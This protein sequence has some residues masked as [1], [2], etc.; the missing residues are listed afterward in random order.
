MR[1]FK[2]LKTGI[3]TVFVLGVIWTIY[4]FT[5]SVYNNLDNNNLNYIPS[6]SDVIIQIDATQLIKESIEGLLV[7]EDNE[8]VQ[9]LKD[10]Q[11]EGTD[12]EG[13]Q[14]GIALN[15]DVLFSLLKKTIT[16]YMVR[17]ST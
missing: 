9:L 11:G 7:T 16:S 14:T 1:N 6:N 13:K 5:A 12:S 15:T 3:Q 10:L 17:C 4:F 8:I 2:I